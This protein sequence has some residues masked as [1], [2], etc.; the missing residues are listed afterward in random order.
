MNR[1]LQQAV[2]SRQTTSD[3]ARLARGIKE[4]LGLQTVTFKGI[5]TS[6]HFARVLVEA[7]YRMKLVGIGFPKNFLSM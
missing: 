5:P 4:N 3:A 2:A 7:D 6:T 1:F